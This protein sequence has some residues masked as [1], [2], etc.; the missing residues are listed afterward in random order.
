[1]HNLAIVMADPPVSH[2]EFKSMIHRL[3]ECCLASAITVN[4]VDHQNIIREFWKTAKMKRDNDGAVIVEAVVKGCKI[5]ITEQFI[6][7]ALLIDDQ[8]GFPIEIGIEDVQ[9][10]LK[11]MGYENNFPPT[12]KKLLPPY[13][14]FLAHV[15]VSC[16][17]GRRSGADEISLRNMGAIASVA[18][19]TDFNFS[20]FIIDE[21]V[22]NINAITRDT[23][24]MYPRFIQMFIDI[25]FPEIFKE[26]DTLDMKS[27]GPYT[28]G[29]IKQNL[30]GKVVFQG[31]YQL[32]KFGK[33]AELNEASESH[34][35]SDKL[36]YEPTSSERVISDDD[37]ITMSDHDVEEDTMVPDA[38]VVEEH[39]LTSVRVQSDYD[40]VTLE[41]NA[42]LLSNENFD[43]FFDNIHDVAHPATDI[44]ETE[45][46]LESTPPATKQGILDSVILQGLPTQPSTTTPIVSSRLINEGTSTTY[47]AGGS[48]TPVGFFPLRPGHDVASVRLAMHLAQ[49]QSSMPSSQ[50]KGSSIGEGHLGGD[51]PTLLGLQKEINMLNQ[52][53]IKLDIQVA[54]PLTENSK[55]KIQVV[56]LEEDKVLKKKQIT[57]LLTYFVLLTAT[58][59]QT[60]RVV[61]RFDKEPTQAPNVVALKCAKLAKAAEKGQLLF[62]RSSDQNAPGDQPNITVTDLGEKRFRDVYGDRSG[63][64]S[65]GFH[66]TLNMWIVRRKSG[67]TEL[68]KYAYD[69]YSWTRVDLSELSKAF[70][71]NPSQNPKATQFKHFLK[72]KDGKLPTISVEGEDDATWITILDDLLIPIGDSPI[73]AMLSNVF[74]DI[75]NRLSD[76]SYLKER[77]ILCLTNDEVDNIN[78][79]VLESVPNHILY[80]KVGAQIILLRN[81]NLQK[82]LCNGTRLVVM[83]I[84]QRVL[85]AFIITGT[86]VGKKVLIGRV[87]MTPNDISWPFRFKRRQFPV[88]VC[89]ATT[90]NKSQCQTFNHVCVYLS[91]PIFAH[92]QLYATTSRVTSRDGLRFYIDNN[93]KCA[94]NLTK[95]VAYKEVFYNLHLH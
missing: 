67:N 56:D 53:N 91:Q 85:E 78:L 55:L 40:E 92:G 73:Q 24:L 35:S 61:D 32:V 81:L 48:S 28:V 12:V 72:I 93:G 89:F 27:L 63:I 39:D 83:Q 66:D 45:D 57:D 33:F 94:N 44:Q 80:L 7:E 86:R 5:E 52:K 50:A 60:P 10:I 47:E 11:K 51:N 13:W 95:I 88:K 82:G 15:Y 16:I 71:A 29:L 49:E 46:V 4:P 68:Y 9:K 34:G 38:L 77:C 41:S 70:F 37:I 1:M 69:F 64:I 20:K 2:G 76:F 42:N 43:M 79:H 8:P 21:F 75:L 74:T 54:D 19:G 25:Q 59:A 6:R 65:W 22:V 31:K 87:D 30:K 23:F 3:R 17:F 36:S 62:K 26:G 14:R 84:S 58:S 18:A 90:I